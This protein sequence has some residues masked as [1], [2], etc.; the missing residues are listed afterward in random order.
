M[1]FIK[2]GITV[3]VETVKIWLEAKVLLDDVPINAHAVST[4][5]GEKHS[6]TAESLYIIDSLIDSVTLRRTKGKRFSISVIFK[7]VL[8]SVHPACHIKNNFRIRQS[9]HFNRTQYN[10]FFIQNANFLYFLRLFKK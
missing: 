7:T 5:H 8:P 9:I 6:D 3:S 10:F 1:V 4:F 2:K